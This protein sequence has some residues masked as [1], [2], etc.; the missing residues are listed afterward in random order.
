MS[1]LAKAQPVPQL[2]TPQDVLRRAMILTHIHLK[3]AAA[4]PEEVLSKLAQNCAEEDREKFTASMRSLLK[5]QQNRIRNEGLWEFMEPS[6]VEFMETRA[7]EMTMRQRIDSSW[8]IESIG[9]LCW[10]L[11][12]LRQLPS[13]DQPVGK[14]VIAFP[15][16]ETA[17]TMLENAEL[18]D[19]H[20]IER[21]RDWAEL[22][23]WRARTQMLLRSGEMPPGLPRGARL[24]EIFRLSAIGA[25]GDGAFEAPIE[26]DFPAFGKPFRAVDQAQ[27]FSLISIASER[28]KAFNWLCGYA[29]EN[30][31]DETPTDT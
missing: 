20:E 16:G 30:R 23:H 31:W 11:G 3:G 13:Y 2:L 22:W 28:H 26:N 5:T 27:L 25:A 1:S 14:E 6:E 10:A 12:Y 15:K 17:E 21:Q 8:V 7:M 29:P 4:P 19:E 24:N 18:R 9:C